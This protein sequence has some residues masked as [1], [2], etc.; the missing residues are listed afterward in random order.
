MTVLERTA[1]KNWSV[2]GRA[3][4]G[5]ELEIVTDNNI[6]KLATFWYAVI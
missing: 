2:D 3:V 6:Y 4:A 5:I 1:E